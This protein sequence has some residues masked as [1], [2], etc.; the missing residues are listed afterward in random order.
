[1]NNNLLDALYALL[2]DKQNYPQN[3]AN[4]QLIETHISKVYLTGDYAYKIK[5]PVDFGFLNFT[6]LTDRQFYCQEEVRLNSRLAENL[7]IDVVAI[8]IENNK[9][10]FNG[11]GEAIEYAVKMHQFDTT[12]QLDNLFKANKL[13]NSTAI[14]IAN[15]VASFH[16][17]ATVADEQSDF[18]NPAQVFAPMQQNFEQIHPMLNKSLDKSHLKTL[19]DWSQKTRKTV[20]P[21]LVKRKQNGFVKECH[22]DMHLGNMTFYKDTLQIFD[23]IE[24][25]DEFKWID[26]TSEVAFFCMDLEYLG[27][28]EFAHL[29]LNQYL[30]NNGDYQLLE[31][32]NFYKVY[33]ALVRAKIALFT[34]ASMTENSPEWTAQWESYRAYIQLAISYTQKK[35]PSN[36]T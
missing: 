15:K 30:E 11:E 7:Y 19:E 4:I 34:A 14:E 20:D 25:N 31:L 36:V 22:G 13:N 32:L 35:K 29:F 26:T 28:T 18:G 16:G 1:M 23:G 27:A 3:C 10:V 8:S 24:F 2:L 33:R 12:Q 17:Q 21:L 9:I 6:K 5:K